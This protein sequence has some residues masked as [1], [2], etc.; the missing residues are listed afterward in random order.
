MSAVYTDQVFVVEPTGIEPVTQ[1][2]RHG[3]PR[4][5]FGLWFSANAEIATWTVG[6]LAVALY[7]TGLAAAAAGILVGNV[8]GFALLGALSLLGPRYGVPQMVA[9]RLSFGARANTAPAALAFLAGIGWFTIGTILGA[10]ALQTIANVPYA[11]ALAIMLT[12]QVLLAVYGYNLIHRFE[13]VCAILLAGGFVLLG[14]HT[15]PHASWGAGFNPRAPL[16]SGGGIAGFFFTVA[17]SFSYACGWMPY[18]SDYTR[19]LPRASSASRVWWFAFAG[20]ALPC[21]ALQIM[22]AATVTAAPHVD[23]SSSIPTEAIAVLLGHGTIATLVLIAVVLGTLTS[24]CMNLY[25]GALAALVA[26]NVRVRR[27]VAALAVGALGALLAVAG[28]DPRHTADLYTNFLLLLSYW[29]APWAAVVLIDAL[30]R[31]GEES[32]ASV[33]LWRPGFVAW[34]AGIAASVPFWSQAWFTGPVAQRFP[35]I[36]DLSYEIG[37]AVS[38]AVMLALGG[39]KAA[40][41]ATVAS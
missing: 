31:R 26:F 14:L 19:Y 11:L 6:V 10:Y 21:I 33:P 2:Q 34:L 37:F 36:G 40:P 12:L 13:S 23:L 20:C 35:A 25:S 4:D 39:R 1:A 16:A 3:S 29:V 8:A 7:G 27:A 18:A 41:I 17:L 9:S 22:G 5:L 24:N 15:L 30:Q 28:A 38:A 32:A